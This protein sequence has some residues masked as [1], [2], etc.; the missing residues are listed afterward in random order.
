MFFFRVWSYFDGRRHFVVTSRA[1]KDAGGDVPKSKLKLLEGGK[2][3]NM[4]CWKHIT[5]DPPEKGP[6]FAKESTR[7]SWLVIIG[8]QQRQLYPTIITKNVFSRFPHGCFILPRM[9]LGQPAKVECRV[10][11]GGCQ[12][13]RGAKMGFPQHCRPKQSESWSVWIETSFFGVSIPSFLDMPK[14]LLVNWFWE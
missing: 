14:A 9:Y 11:A 13:S 3:K 4:W 2:Q 10:W 5:H 7:T 6:A 1:L 8:S 12:E